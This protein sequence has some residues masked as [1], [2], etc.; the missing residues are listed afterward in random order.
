MFKFVAPWLTASP[1]L[2]RPARAAQLLRAAEQPAIEL[3]R[4]I[5]IASYGHDELLMHS[6]LK[7]VDAIL[8]TAGVS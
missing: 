5:R 1:Q 2:S 4:H 8:K 7:E 6:L 3:L